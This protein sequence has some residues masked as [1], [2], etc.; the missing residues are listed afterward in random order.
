MTSKRFLSNPALDRLTLLAKS[1]GTKRIVL[2]EAT[3]LRVLQAART[4]TDRGIAKVSLIGNSDVVTK[5]AD[6]NSINLSGIDV[7]NPVTDERFPMLVEKFAELR[8]KKGVTAEQARQ[9]CEDPQIFGNML[10][11]LAFADGSVSGAVATSGKT[12]QA[13]VWCLGLQKGIEC[14]SS[15][16]LMAF[17]PESGKKSMIYADCG[18]V[19]DP[20]ASQLACITKSSAE[21]CRL[22]L[23]EEPRVAMLSFSTHGSAKHPNVDKV[24]EACRIVRE[25]DPSLLVD[26]DLQFDAAIVPEIAA[27]KAPTSP[28]AGDANVFIFPD[29]QS[30]NIAYK[31]TERLAQASAIGPI[32]QGLAYPANDVSRGCNSEDLVNAIAITSI[33]AQQMG[34]IHSQ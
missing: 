8:K 15:F 11:R 14:A 19:I 7:L 13:A 33:Q 29:L 9:I 16:F 32:F 5:L 21:S 31:I 27:K 2:P 3:D 6:S 10:V 23:G 17:P 4:A 25:S 28:I 18:F 1:G 34:S 26:G 12:A 22:F 20:T 24:Q 30:G